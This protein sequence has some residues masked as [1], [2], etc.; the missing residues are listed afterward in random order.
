MEQKNEKSFVIIILIFAIS[1]LSVAYASL[2]QVLKIRVEAYV[3]STGSSWSINF[4][5]PS[6]AVIIGDAEA[7]TIDV[8]NTTILLYN[9]ILK[10]PGSSVTYTFDITN[11]GDIEAKISSVQQMNPTILGTGSDK[12]N[13]EELVKNNYVYKITYTDGAPIIVGDLLKVGETKS[14]KLTISYSSSAEL[15]K[16]DVIISDIGTIIM[17]EQA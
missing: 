5:K 9:V 6:D 11:S 3:A 1:A 15:P 4:E 12:E 17:Y 8:Q 2:A 7:G 10:Q 16:Q 14:F 13:D